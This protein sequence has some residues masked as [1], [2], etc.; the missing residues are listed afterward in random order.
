MS[1]D[2]VAAI[3]TPLGPGGIGIIRISGPEAYTILNRLFKRP[4][5]AV[6]HGKHA[7]SG[8]LLL[9]HRV[10]YGFIIDPN[11][12]DILDE[13]LAIIMRGPKSFTR[14]DV[15]EIHSHSGFVVLN[16]ILSAVVDAGARLADPGEFTKRAFLNGRIDLTQAEAIIDLINA[17]CETAAQIASSQI[18]G[19]LRD[20][21]EAL[22]KEIL[23]LQ[24][25]VEAMVEF[26]EDDG[27]DQSERFETMRMVL[28]QSIIP[29]ITS[30]IQRQE[31]TMVY[32]QGLSL[33]IAGMP[34]V[35]KSSLLNRLVKKEAAIVSEFPGTTRD[36]VREYVSIKGVPVVVCDTAGIHD[37]NDPV[38]CIGIEKAHKQ[39]RVADIILLV[40]EATQP[41]NKFELRLFS[42]CRAKK[43]IIVINK[44]DIAAET[45]VA[46][47]QSAFDDLPSI[48]VSAKLGSGLEKLKKEIFKGV[49]VESGSAEGN[50]ISPNLRQRKLLEIAKRDLLRL[51]QGL[52]TNPSPDLV[53]DMMNNILNGLG[54]I[55]GGR[56]REDLYD[57]IFSQFCVGK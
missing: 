6:F 36:I 20:A 38:E 1:S 9:T 28:C 7:E 50:W 52:E 42:Q 54:E 45:A 39:I 30:L 5:K 14:E 8:S 22:T 10:Y 57:Q 29:K 51:T 27:L 48:R 41:L 56:T 15:V 12:G 19:G 55:S 49:V 46:A 23:S 44:D 25:T 37:T 2:T 31:D 17:P 4:S 24:A 43:T 40:V 34:N 11:G 21:V 47:I 18:N 35:G 33:T 3:S 16:R 32:R 26:A 13:V 53:S